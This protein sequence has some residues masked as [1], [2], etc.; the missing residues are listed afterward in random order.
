M[1]GTKRH[2]PGSALEQLIQLLDHMIWNVMELLGEVLIK[3]LGKHGDYLY[4]YVYI[5][6]IYE[7]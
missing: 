7:Q 6:L 4:T 3:N 2:T 5:C 1:L